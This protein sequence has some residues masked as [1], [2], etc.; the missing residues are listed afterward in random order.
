MASH[1]FS[2]EEAL[3][4]SEQAETT[5]FDRLHRAGLSFGISFCFDAEVVIIV[6]W[7]IIF[8]SSSSD[9]VSPWLTGYE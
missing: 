8:G 1:A 4:G 2:P 6:I 7:V 5:V 9:W 3:Y